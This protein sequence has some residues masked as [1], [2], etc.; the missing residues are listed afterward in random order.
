MY[1]RCRL[2]VFVHLLVGLQ[3]LRACGELH[4]SA[5]VCQ[6]VHA[7]LLNDGSLSLGA[8]PCFQGGSLGGV[9]HYRVVVHGELVVAVKDIRL[10]LYAR[11]FGRLRRNLHSCHGLSAL[12]GHASVDVTRRRAESHVGERLAAFEQRV[13]TDHLSL[14]T[15]VVYDARYGIHI[16]IIVVFLCLV[17]FG[18][19]NLLVFRIRRAMLLSV[20][21]EALEA[22]AAAP[23][24]LD[25]VSDARRHQGFG[26]RH[27]GLRAVCLGRLHY[28]T[29]T[30][31]VAHHYHVVHILAAA[32]YILR[33]FD[34]V[35]R[36][37]RHIHSREYR[38]GA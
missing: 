3:G 2:D 9:L 14:H 36:V 18:H 21:H 20:Y 10:A 15:V 34:V 6:L 30:V 35:G 23:C 31:F 29:V 7:R 32:E 16:I 25:E 17:A 22:A 11:T 13:G 37:V 19:G 5:I 12:K 27:R 24:Q 28:E 8:H 38:L 26:S 33:Q 1:E 4:L